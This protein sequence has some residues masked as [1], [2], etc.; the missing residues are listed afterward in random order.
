MPELRLPDASLES[1]SASPPVE[2]RGGTTPVVDIEDSYE[3]A[4]EVSEL[5]ELVE[6]LPVE[7]R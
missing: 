2:I 3:H 5:T 7:N 6:E 1:P 4:D